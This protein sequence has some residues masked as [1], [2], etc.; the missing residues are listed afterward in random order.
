MRSSHIIL[1][2]SLSIAASTIAAPIKS[3]Q[4]VESPESQLPAM[5][6]D[7]EA[8]SFQAFTTPL[9]SFLVEFDLPATGVVRHERIRLEEQGEFQGLA[10]S[11]RARVEEQH[12][13]FALYLT[14]DLQLEYVLRHEFFT[15][16]NGMSIDLQGVPP[17][18]LP[19]ILEQIRSMPGVVNVSPLVR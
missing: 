6:R 12:K 8:D 11:R 9:S 13:N 4:D 3:K 5:F 14:D 15:L 19:K 2:L 18:K 7:V 17:N 1:T 16:M 10:A